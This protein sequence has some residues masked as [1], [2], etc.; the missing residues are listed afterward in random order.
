MNLSHRS[1]HPGLLIQTPPPDAG[2]SDGDESNG[3]N[4]S[5]VLALGPTLD[6]LDAFDSDQ[7]PNRMHLNV[8]TLGPH[9]GFIKCIR[10]GPGVRIECI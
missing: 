2:A 1:W 6:S 3:S 9:F 7:G 10:F 8:L 4:A 5:Q